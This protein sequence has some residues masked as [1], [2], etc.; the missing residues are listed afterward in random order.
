MREWIAGYVWIVVLVV[1]MPAV[2]ILASRTL[3]HVYSWRLFW[4]IPLPL[5]I[6]LGGGINAGVIGTRRWRLAAHLRLWA[7]AFAFADSWAVSGKNFS[8][9]NLGRPEVS[10]V[11]YAVAEA[12]ISLAPQ[13]R[14]P[15]S[16]RNPLRCA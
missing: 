10:D 7:A 3:G 11:P 12:T 9:K 2:S 15:R 5:L 16:C 13:G 4:A 6:S 1:F 8:L 14:A